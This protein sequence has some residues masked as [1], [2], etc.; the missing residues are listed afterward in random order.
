M[1]AIL[2]TNH[3]DITLTLFGNQ[4]PKTVDNFVGLATG[5]AD[6]RDDAG[7]TSPT[8]FYDG[9]TFHRIILNFMIQGGCP[10]GQG[11]GGPGYTFDDEI[12]PELRFDKPYLLAMANAGK[13]MGKGTNGS[14]FF[15]TTTTPDWLNG[16]HTIFGEVADQA[17]RDVVDAI[18]AVPTGAMDKPTEPVVI[19]SVE[20][21][22][23]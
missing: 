5:K 9:L 20:I 14:Q 13:R 4:A 22:E 3:G 21:L 2:H 7:R 10:V 18:S 11:V 6:Y 19:E 8:P 16:K 15:I 1:K 12:H 17:G 23:D